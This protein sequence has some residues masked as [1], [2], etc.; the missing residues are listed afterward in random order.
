MEKPTCPPYE[1]T[2]LG[3]DPQL[4]RFSTQADFP[5]SRL[6][7]SDPDLVIS[8]DL[9]ADSEFKPRNAAASSTPAAIFTFL[10][11]NPSL[12][13]IHA[14]L[15]FLLPNHTDGSAAEKG[16]MTLMRAGKVPLSGTI[17]VRAVGSGINAIT[18]RVY[19]PEQEENHK[20]VARMIVYEAVTNP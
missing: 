9:Y 1:P 14:S 10:L 19:T 11:G 20:P 7:F 5:V 2:C 13:T 16:G 8:T 18:H 17:G 6:R 4:N 3:D 15:L 12:Q